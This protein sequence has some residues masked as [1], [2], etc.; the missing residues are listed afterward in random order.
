M[1]EGMVERHYEERFSSDVGK[2]CG[3]LESTVDD[4]VIRGGYMAYLI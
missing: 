3:G 2:I 1:N 4:G